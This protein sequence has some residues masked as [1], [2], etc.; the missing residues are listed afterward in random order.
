MKNGILML[1]L[2]I[3]GLI[4]GCG[5]TTDIK[6]SSG[7]SAYQVIDARGTVV[8]L[9]GK[10]KR[11]V[12]LSASTDAIIL[13]MLPTEN[14]VAISTLLDDPVSSN[15]VNKARKI[16]EKIRNPSAERILSLQPDLV[17]VPDWKEAVIVDSLRDLGLKVVV[18]KGPQSVA[19]VRE[20]VQLLA[21]ATGE[22]R[23][24]NQ[25]IAKMDER[26][27]SIKK[28]VDK[29]PADKRKTVVLIS[30]MASYGGSGSAFDDMC[31]YAGVVN[32][33]AASGIKNGQALS[34]ERLVAIN[35]DILLM[36]VYNDH[37][38]YDIEAFRR[39]FLEDPALQTLTAIKE[40][41]LYMP[42]E[43]YVYNVSQDIVFGIQEIALAA[44]GEEFAQP[45][46]YHISV[47]D[48]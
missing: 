18:C 3:V 47:V 19:E 24:G 40:K 34:K 26:L 2:V 33:L 11:I 35:P 23:K 22:E 16:P 5:S 39:E 14:L 1:L 25:L 6:A 4:C 43:G 8:E 13:G 7:E 45:A 29:I 42:R 37:G 28:K 20:T 12:T 10:P 30:L 31:Q 41:R 27:Q 21:K 9:P 32:G 48:E 36:P 46:D 44:Y 15:I 38:T 17:I